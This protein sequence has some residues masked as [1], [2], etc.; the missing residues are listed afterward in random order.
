[1]NRRGFL[2][3]IFG[4]AMAGAAL[5]GPAVAGDA[6]DLTP[7]EQEVLRE[8]TEKQVIYLPSRKSK[9]FNE[10][11]RKKRNILK[12]LVH[13]NRVCIDFSIAK[14]NDETSETCMVYYLPRPGKT[15]LD[16]YPEED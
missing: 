1:M 14:P 16:N 9:L 4:T 7:A 6:Y 5:T 13:K 15:P 10:E 8:L 11:L 3:G 12:R 2:G